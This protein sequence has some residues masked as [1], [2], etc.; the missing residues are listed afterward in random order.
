MVTEACRCSAL[1]VCRSPCKRVIWRSVP[2]E[3]PRIQNHGLRAFGNDAAEV[4]VS[5]VQE[6]VH[7][8]SRHHRR[9]H[10]HDRSLLAEPGI[11][12][13]AG[14]VQARMIS[15]DRQTVFAMLLD[16]HGSR[17]GNLDRHMRSGH[18]PDTRVGH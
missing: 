5:R 2:P 14:H 7:L 4:R 3:Q 10:Q 16:T 12:E 17:D 13:D 6:H 8:P 15:T 11:A 18:A 9:D 1:F